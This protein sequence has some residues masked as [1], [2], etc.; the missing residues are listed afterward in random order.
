M[1]LPLLTATGTPAGVPCLGDG[2]RGR[3]P[4]RLGRDRGSA[5]VHALSADHRT[6]AL[7]YSP[8][9]RAVRAEVVPG[10]KTSCLTVSSD[11]RAVTAPAGDARTGMMRASPG[12]AR[13][14]VS[15]R[16]WKRA[17]RSR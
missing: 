17:V 5:R 9:C 7:W 12:R 3:T 4:Y 15:G 11:S 13:G 8:V 14:S 1:A 6:L 10:V 16:F 2:C